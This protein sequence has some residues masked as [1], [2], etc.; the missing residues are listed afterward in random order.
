MS[1]IGTNGEQWEL[2]ESL[3]PIAQELI[4]QFPDQVGHVELQH[5]VFVKVM[6]TRNSDD[7]LGKCW[8]IN[9]PRSIIPHFVL[10]I[11]S[12]K[13]ILKPSDVVVDDDYDLLDLKYIIGINEDR[14]NEVRDNQEEVLKVLILHEMMHIKL[15]M[16]GIQD[17]TTKDF[18]YILDQFGVYWASGL[19]EKSFSDKSEESS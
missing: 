2:D 18:S 1:L 6:G 9:A 11:L 16:N 13:N 17:H 15:E 3:R 7:W 19:M 14:L 10:K 4:N 12:L 8:Y 5:I